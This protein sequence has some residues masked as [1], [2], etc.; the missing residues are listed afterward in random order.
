MI[1]ITQHN[2]ATVHGPHFLQ[3]LGHLN[4]TPANGMELGTLLGES[5]EWMLQNIFT[6]PDSSYLCVDTFRGSVEHGGSEGDWAE[7]EATTRAKLCAYPQATVMKSRSADW[8]KV[9]WGELDFIFIDAAHDSLNVL[10]DSVLAFDL[11][12]VGGVLVWD[13][14]GW[15]VMPDPLD[16]PKVAIDA[17]LGVYARQVEVLHKGWLVAVKKTHDA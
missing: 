9:G 7:L 16:C 15:N 6:H 3:W 12:K 5:A 10:R 4:G 8:M 1:S 2:V 13:D 17:F 14:Y 11:L